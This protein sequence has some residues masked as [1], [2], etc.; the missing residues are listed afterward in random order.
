M[1]HILIGKFLLSYQANGSHVPGSLAHIYG[2]PHRTGHIAH[3]YGTPH[4]T[5]YMANILLD[6]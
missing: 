2:L 1:S 4:L 6:I 3:I 5:S